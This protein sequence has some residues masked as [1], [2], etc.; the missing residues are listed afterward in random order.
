M[1]AEPHSPGATGSTPDPDQCIPILPTDTFPPPFM[2][3][4]ELRIHPDD[5]GFARGAK[6][7]EPRM[8]GWFRL[9][10][11]DYDRLLQRLEWIGRTVVAQVR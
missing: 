10:D 9:R 8:R 7:G 6:S 5:A 2:G 3:Q 11:E 4:V 1:T